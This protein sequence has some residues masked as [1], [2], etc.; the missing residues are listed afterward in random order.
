MEEHVEVFS[1]YYQL[2]SMAPTSSWVMGNNL[3][4]FH[5]LS[6]TFDYQMI[7]L[8]GKCSITLDIFIYHN[9]VQLL[10]PSR[11]LDLSTTE[12]VWFWGPNVEGM[13]SILFHLSLPPHPSPSFV[14]YGSSGYGKG[15][16]LLRKLS[17]S[18]DHQNYFKVTTKTSWNFRPRTECK[19]WNLN[20]VK[21]TV[22]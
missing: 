3:V 1:N 15:I 2:T 12:L 18:R 5:K 17:I 19:W 4:K 14:H 20:N 21:I 9:L 6:V 10:L 16:Y 7:P 8:S 13:W 11:C 22:I